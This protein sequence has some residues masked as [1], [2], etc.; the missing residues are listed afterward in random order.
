MLPVEK[1]TEIIG[2][3]KFLR[4]KRFFCIYFYHRRRRNSKVTGSRKSVQVLDCCFSN[5][6]N[7]CLNYRFNKKI[8][9]INKSIPLR[10]LNGKRIVDIYV[11]NW[12]ATACVPRIEKISI[13]IIYQQQQLINLDLAQITINQDQTVKKEQFFS[14]SKM[15]S[16]DMFSRPSLLQQ[17]ICSVRKCIFVSEQLESQAKLLHEVLNCL[18]YHDARNPTTNH[19]QPCTT[20]LVT[21]QRS[22][23]SA[24]LQSISIKPKSVKSHFTLDG[25]FRP[26]MRSKVATLNI[27]TMRNKDKN[28]WKLQELIFYC[29]QHCVPILAIQEHRLI[30]DDFIE[31]ETTELE[32]WKFIYSSA[33]KAG[34]G[35]VGFLI[36]IAVFKNLCSIKKV[37]DRILELNLGVSSASNSYKSTIYC[38]YSYTGCQGP[39]YIHNIEELFYKKLN[40]AVQSVPQGSMMLIMGDF[41]AKLLATLAHPF[42][43]NRRGRSPS[44]NAKYLDHL[45]VENNL[46]VANMIFKK[47]SKSEYDT[48]YGNNLECDSSVAPSANGLNLIKR[49]CCL[50]Y[51]LIRSKWAN[52]LK[53]CFVKRPTV[54]TD[55]CFVIAIIQWSFRQNSKTVAL[56]PKK[57]LSLLKAKIDPNDESTMLTMLR[58]ENCVKEN[59][60][61]DPR[62]GV[63]NYPSLVTAINLACEQVL[64]NITSYLKSKPW[65]NADIHLM[66]IQYWKSQCFSRKYPTEDNKGLTK[67]LSRQL[68]S[69]Y[70][71]AQ[72]AYYT[73]L[74]NRVNEAVGD[75][76]SQ[77]A[78][79]LVNKLTSRKGIKRDIIAAD[80]GEAR[81]KLWFEHFQKLLSPE[82][83]PTRADCGIN[84]VF[85]NLK[86]VI[87][88]FEEEELETAANMLK[89][90]K[91][92]GIDGIMGEI[93]KHPC[94][95]TTL[96]ELFNICYETKTV[97]EAWHQSLLVPVFKKGNPAICGNYRGIALMSI[98]AKL[99]NLM[100]LMRL[101]STLEPH[102]RH[103][104]NGFR[105]GRSTAQQVLAL[106]RLIEEI[107][108]VK[109][110]KLITVFVDFS[111]AFDSVDWN[112]IENILLA[113]DV[114]KEMVDAI[115][116]VYFGAQA[117]V[118]VDG[119]VSSFFDLGIGVLQGDTLA[120]FLFVIVLDWVLRNALNDEKLGLDLLSNANVG[121]RNCSRYASLIT[122][123]TDLCY[124]DDIA[125]VTDSVKNANIMLASISL[126]ANKVGLKIN[127]G[128]SKTEYIL[129]GNFSNEDVVISVDNKLLAQVQDY[130]YLGSWIMSSEKD[131]NTRKG[132]AWD[133]ITK[134]DNIWRSKEFSK[135]M[136]F[137]FFQS[138]IE[139]ILFY[140]ATTWNISPLLETR[141]TGTYHKL[142]RYALNVNYSQ[143]L[144]NDEVFADIAYVPVNIRLRKLRLTFVGHCW[145]C[146]TYSYQAVSDLIFWKLHGSGAN[147]YYDRLLSDVADYQKGVNSLSSV[148]K[149]QNMMMKDKGKWHE[150]VNKQTNEYNAMR[151]RQ[152]NRHMS[153]RKMSDHSEVNMKKKIKKSSDQPDTVLALA[154]PQTRRKVVIKGQKKDEYKV[155]K[156]KLFLKGESTDVV[157][158]TR[159]RM[160]ES[161]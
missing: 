54:S 27:Q 91:S 118:K 130:K 125:L 89:N 39:D 59:Y 47:N 110:K 69:L 152:S 112:Y 74:C 34:T 50:D 5:S 107:S 135:M 143:H 116:S 84:K 120:P 60:T 45:L 129:V 100:L 17:I 92:A 12:L 137:L 66:R 4:N 73:A 58:W 79:D 6:E 10:R 61:L 81:L 44:H 83:K 155:S 161:K 144:T 78:W 65:M 88:S 31:L 109:D 145:R 101:R 86:W 63:E 153:K 14:P 28:H 94:I 29:E 71:K 19:H 85:N 2:T 123:L 23:T 57:D 33:T 52:S 149:L 9:R 18:A 70:T 132:Q 43:A 37:S 7:V 148:S 87:G 55:H 151:F 160:L 16:F 147:N 115:M 40:D 72:D 141:I 35:G 124:A 67:G 111:K 122:H 136:K 30:L 117:A 140:N 114:P 41:N 150:Y 82:V 8:K 113:Y 46:T 38:V 48:F 96:L 159:G 11:P 156:L 53:D 95:R 90:D 26:N 106:R 128:K 51:I 103:N 32:G 68:S 119:V 139:S 49:T 126:W 13:P 127:T 20:S 105:Q 157:V 75:K 76:K 21:R 138:L 93:L 97:P 22:A 24:D 77:L 134:L 99:Y 56:V 102:L 25:S 104:Q 121:L 62:I 64:P 108:S 146:R 98:C 3:K 1:S 15:K 133:A 131:F 142:L 158:L 42:T 80:D 154:A 36:S